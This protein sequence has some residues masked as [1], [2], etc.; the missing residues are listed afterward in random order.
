MARTP[1]SK[2]RAQ[3]I[4][5]IEAIIGNNCYNDN[6]QNWGPYGTYE[7]EGREFRYPITFLDGEGNKLKRWSAS[8]MEPDIMRTGYYAFGA[9]R[10]HI[11]KAL[12]EVVAFLEREHSLK[13]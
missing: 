3:L 8:G 2:K 11:M 4:S 9:N 7:G 1:I 13:I 12:D 10:L 6:I 5:Q